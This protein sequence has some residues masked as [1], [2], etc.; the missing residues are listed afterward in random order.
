M[1]KTQIGLA[2]TAMA[3]FG[4]LVTAGVAS[5]TPGQVLHAHFVGPMAVGAWDTGPGPNATSTIVVADGSEL[6][7]QQLTGTEDINDNITNGT[8]ITAEVTSGFSLTID[9][10]QLT[11][12][13]LSASGIPATTCAIDANGD[14]INCTATTLDVTMALTGL[15]PIEPGVGGAQNLHLSFGTAIENVHNS[16]RMRAAN[17]TG[18]LDGSVLVNNIPANN[19]ELAF[20]NQEVIA[21][22]CRGIAC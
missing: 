14:A 13:S 15:G 12:G 20:L 17:A 6:V 2:V 22:I 3:A 10:S 21:Q 19:G 7:V 9:Q 8:L 4:S 11:T 16:G 5:A 1:R 18:N